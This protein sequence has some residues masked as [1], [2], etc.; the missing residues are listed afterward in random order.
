MLDL[1]LKAYH[2]QV[3]LIQKHTLKNIR[4]E[5]SIMNNLVNIKNFNSQLFYSH[6]KFIL[7]TNK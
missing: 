1:R 6:L 3:I 2:H 7:L 4:N 5:F